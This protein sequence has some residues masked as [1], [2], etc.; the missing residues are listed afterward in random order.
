MFD[1]AMKKS[2]E[3]YLQ[4]GEELLN[5]MIVQ[6]KGMTKALL[7]GGAIGATAIGA[8]RD[9]KGK[10][11]GGG[12]AIELSSKMGLAITSRRLL[13]FKAGG[14]VTLSAKEMLSG[15]PL[16]DVDSVDV[17]KGVLTKPVTLTVSGESFQVEAPKAANTKEFVAAFER[18]KAGSAAHAL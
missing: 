4:E 16:A 8:M 7:A 13:V 18:A 6:G 12:G 11:E 3:P 2:I 1:K 15:V 10:A 9:R 5:V 14:A 17:G